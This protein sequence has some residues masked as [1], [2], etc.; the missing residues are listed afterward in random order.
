ML[1]N[2]YGLFWRADE[3][4]WRGK[5]SGP[6]FQLLGRAGAKGSKLRLADFRAQ[7]GLY[8]L[9]SDYGP[10]YVGLTRDAR[11]G[12]R[13]RAHA[14]RDRHRGKWDRFSWFGF[15]KVYVKPGHHRLCDLMPLKIGAMKVDPKNEI[16]DLEALLIKA[17][18]LQ[19]NLRQ[20]QFK[21][22]EAWIQVKLTDVAA[23][24]SRVRPIA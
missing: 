2:A 23:Y 11:L 17:L 24:I 4:N 12:S 15:R 13:L 18:G 14:V 1:I 22:A 19:S 20:E 21:S 5:G 9:Y 3:V 6:K 7:S 16:G 8:I 10:Y